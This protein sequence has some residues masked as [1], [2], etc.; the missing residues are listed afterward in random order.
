MELDYSGM[1]CDG[2]VVSRRDQGGG[3]GIGIGQGEIDVGSEDEVFIPV[4]GVL[5][6][7][8]ELVGFGD[9]EGKFRRAVAVGV[10]S[11]RAS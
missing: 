9:L 1:A 4:F 11:V 10:I 2:I 7:I 3:E 5:A 8:D 6:H